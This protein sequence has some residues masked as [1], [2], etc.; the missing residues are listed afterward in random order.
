MVISGRRN[1][2]SE[3]DASAVSDQT[4]Y[5]SGGEVTAPR[6]SVVVP[7]NPGE[8]FRY[9]KEDAASGH[10]YQEQVIEATCTAGGYT[11]HICTS[12]Q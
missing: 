3:A 9:D 6:D 11:L 5:F 12:C 2:S 4:I 8:D 10:T 1:F 7:L